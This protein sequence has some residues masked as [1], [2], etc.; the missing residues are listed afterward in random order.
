MGDNLQQFGEKLTNWQTARLPERDIFGN[1]CVLTKYNPDIHADKLFC[2]YQQS[3]ESWNYLPYGPFNHYEDF[4]QWSDEVTSLNDPFF[5]VIL[6]NESLPVG[7]ASYLR[8]QPSIGSIEIG[9]LHFSPLMSRSRM[10][11]E[12]LYLMIKYAFDMGYRRVEW[13]C[14]SLNQASRNAALRLGFTYEGTFRQ[15]TI[16]KNRNR[17]T[18]WFSIIDGEW[19][20]IQQ[21][22]K[23][24]LDES[25]FDSG[26][27]QINKLSNL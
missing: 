26:G 19:S 17:D 4:L 21:R 23:A 22:F 12:A 2:A 25:N 18:A 7:L 27:N 1:D 15:A 11:T 9:H 20:A 8:I 16:Y 10:S 6:N 14:D 3:N 24:W 5:Y 13:K